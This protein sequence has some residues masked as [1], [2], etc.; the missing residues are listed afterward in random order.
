MNE[1]EQLTHEEYTHFLAYGE[2]V[3]EELDPETQALLELTCIDVP[4]EGE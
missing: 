4:E 1:I 3:S 2:D